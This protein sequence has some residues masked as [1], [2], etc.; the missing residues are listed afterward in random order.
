MKKYKFDVKLN[1]SE[2]YNYLKM[3]V[4]FKSMEF[5]KIVRRDNGFY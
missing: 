3:M 2:I 1:C 4:K 5:V